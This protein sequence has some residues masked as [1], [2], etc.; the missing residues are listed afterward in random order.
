MTLASITNLIFSTF[1]V[2]GHIIIVAVL[3]S[4]FL[5]K[6]KYANRLIQFF[7]KNALLFALIVSV[8]ATGGSLF[9]SDVLGYN[10]CK[11][12]WLQRIFMY[13]QVVL[14]GLALWKND[15]TVAFYSTALA[16]IGGLIALYH[17]LSQL[18]LLPAVCSTVGYS[19]SCSQKFVLQLGYITIPLMSLTA[20][21]LI[22]LL[23]NINKF[24]KSIFY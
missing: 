5:D 22:I 7:G 1:T 2:V 21:L 9:Y 18:G 10:P 24:N 3:V 17:Y 13:P 12:C 19:V 14:L 6:N 20:F 23:L 4:I 15:L 11:L 8:A 16:V